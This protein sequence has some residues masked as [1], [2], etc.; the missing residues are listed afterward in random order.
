MNQTILE[1]LYGLASNNS[2]LAAPA[3]FSAV[4]LPYLIILS[5]AV[6]AVFSKNK[7]FRRQVIF[8]FA[9]TFA[10]WFLVF[11]FK[12][13]FP[14]PRPFEVLS[15]IVPLFPHFPDSAFPS[16]HAT[17][18]GA[19]A[20]ALFFLDNK[21]L[22]LWL[23]LAAVLIVVGRVATGVHWPADVIAGLLIGSIGAWVSVKLVSPRSLPQGN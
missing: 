21:R 9:I 12:E 7:K 1:F 22:G 19:L 23:G 5:L 6:G 8:S 20:A 2:W 10:L 18:F 4:Y 3:V 13:F 15:N 14:T 16:G 17:F 11:L